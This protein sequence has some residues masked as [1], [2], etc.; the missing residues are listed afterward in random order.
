MIVG[1]IASITVAPVL[2][3]LLQVRVIESEKNV[4]FSSDG[5]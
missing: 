2:G 1:G 4:L 5:F 3:E